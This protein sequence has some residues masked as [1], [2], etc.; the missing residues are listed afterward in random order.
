MSGKGKEA[1]MFARGARRRFRFS[2][3]WQ[4]PLLLL[5]LIVFLCAACLYVDARP[6]ITL[7]QKL[8]T[9]RELLHCDRP[10]AAIE[11][12]NRLVA[13]ERFDPQAQ[14]QIHLL[15]AEAMDAS[16]KQRRISVPA[17]H[18]R[19]IEETQMAL[20]QGV[21]PTGD[22]HRRLGESYE[23]LGRGVEAVSEYRLAIALDPPKALRLQRKVI[24]LQ[25]AQ[26]DWA[27]AE[28]SLDSYLA[29]TQVADAER[30]WAQSVK[31]QLLIDRH[32]YADA[33]Q[34]LE[35]AQRLD[36]DPIA[37][38]EMKFRIGVCEWKL[39][40]LEDAAKIIAS[41]RGA[42]KH[43]HPLDA[44]AA[45]TLGRIAQEK[46]DLT[47]AVAM[48]DTVI[49][50]YADSTFAP[51]AR[52]NRGLC[53][54]QNRDDAAALS[55]LRAVAD[56]ARTNPLL[57]EETLAALGKT[58]TAMIERSNF[59]AAIELMTLEQA[60]DANP[61]AGFYARLA[62]A[63]EKRSEQIEQSIAD[64]SAPEKVRRVQLARDFAS[65]AGDA[66]LTYCKASIAAGDKNYGE[67][68]FKAI[69]LY[70]RADNSGAIAAAIEAFVADRPSDDLAPEALLR[71]G[72]TYETANQPDEAVVAYRRLRTAYHKTP[73]AMKAAM[74]LANLLQ[75][76]PDSL[77][78]AAAVLADVV[79]DPQAQRNSDEYRS[80]LFQLGSLCCKTGEWKEAANRLGQFAVQFPQ[81]S[82][83]VESAFLLGECYRNL[84]PQAEKKEDRKQRL[85]RAIE[86]YARCGEAESQLKKLAA[87]RR[88][89]CEYEQ[90][91]YAD[92]AGMYETI[93][94]QYPS[95]SAVALAASVQVVN[96]YCA[97]NKTAEARAWN[98][99]ARVLLAHSPEG[100]S[101]VTNTAAGGTVLNK[102]YFEQ[103]LKWS[104]TAV[105]SSW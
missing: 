23:A 40:R 20:A 16:Q 86:C 55:D 100:A 99:R 92:A 64:A 49:N 60:I 24:D 47:T 76:S 80:A 105:A 45:Y 15:L 72:R 63:Y 82:H 68:F 1:S 84:A 27:P 32:E 75:K 59:A 95:D 83:S 37:Q 96:S 50:T 5:S 3:L 46:N 14:A 61:P 58:S 90:G 53:R 78:A 12:I 51:L 104:T 13:S 36:A 103:W 44:D 85:T 9:A 102:P 8:S 42:F 91:Y 54:T 43:Q 26:S 65:K 48:F 11:S 38:A 21:K 52:L 4:L 30:A 41:A 25:L 98:E 18:Q 19:I 56:R 2:H 77:A 62:G 73:S 87:L 34:L 57:R 29:S 39:G 6:V 33:R 70:K 66:E 101:A 71:L 22:I 93:V 79:D 31:A 17:N 81:D 97:L 35:T 89:D 7:T 94:S 88:A 67:S 74:P 28:A 10:D 69:D